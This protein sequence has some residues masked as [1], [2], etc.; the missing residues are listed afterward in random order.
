MNLVFLLTSL[1]GQQCLFS[2][3]NKWGKDSSSSCSIF[4]NRLK[5]QEEENPDM[6]GAMDILVK[7]LLTNSANSMD[8]ADMTREEEGSRGG[9]VL[10]LKITTQ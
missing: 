8:F 2:W 6:G 5:A 3:R 4:E 1:E 10:R 9:G 7:V